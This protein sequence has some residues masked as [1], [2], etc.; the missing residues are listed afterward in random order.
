MGVWGRHLIRVLNDHADVVVCCNRGDS[1]AQDWLRRE[2]PAIRAG[3]SAQE[4]IEDPTVEAVVIATPI[5]THAHLAIASLNAGKH[6]FVEKPLA[7][8]GADAWQV[9]ET[10]EAARRTLFVGHTFLFDR[11]LEALQAIAQADPI[12]RIDLTWL[13]YGTFGEPLVWNLLSHE[14]AIAM[15]FVGATPKLDILERA[16]GQTSV[17]RLRLGLDFGGGGPAGS[18]EIDRMHGH[19]TKTARVRLRSGAEYLWRDGDLYRIT[20]DNHEDRMLERSEE[21][22]VREV[23]A[24]LDGV[25]TGRATRSDGRFGASVV[26][27]IEPVAASLEAA[28]AV[29]GPGR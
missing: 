26:E 3:S 2:Y 9:V 8:G 6:V 18:I 11:S 16:A 29:A 1:E 19:K 15:W 22:L 24:F 5:G 23:K 13:K 7:T 14:V 28:S 12:E 20:L 17:D 25:V 27:V 10:A 21:A 4:A